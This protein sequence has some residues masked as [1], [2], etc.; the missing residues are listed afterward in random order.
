MTDHPRHTLHGSLPVS[1]PQPSRWT[2]GFAD[3]EL[4]AR[5]R[6]ERSCAMRRT[7]LVVLALILVMLAALVPLDLTRLE[8]E[9]LGAALALRAVFAGLLVTAAV[10]VWRRPERLMN[11]APGTGVGVTILTV[12][13]TFVYGLEHA[14][15]VLDIS[16]FAFIGLVFV[17]LLP[18]TGRWRWA[19]TGILLLAVWVV[20]YGKTDAGTGAEAELAGLFVSGVLLALLAIAHREDVLR[21]WQFAAIDRLMRMSTADPLTGVS[22]RRGFFDAAE[23]ARH[24]TRLADE[25]LS[26]V[27][28]DLDFFK[29]VNDQYG[30]AVGDDVLRRVA[31]VLGD[32]L[33]P[34]ETL[35]R[36]G[37]EEFAVL[38][39]GL[40]LERAERR[41]HA[42]RA[43]VEALCIRSGDRVVRMTASVGVACWM[44]EESIDAAL[45]RADLAMYEAKADGRNCVRREVARTA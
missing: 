45:A 6:S 31:R 41:A 9:G 2:G 11:V 14:N 19:L 12:A 38:L 20:A 22:N 34:G 29:R 4:E 5:F 24:R 42:L 25:P 3:E 27:L 1:L 21:R 35:A 36:L 18:N 44:P 37:G 33:K 43:E 40:S 15:P 30:H 26:V 32:A 28:L 7:F 39:P 10:M 17:L 8:D 16:Q 23:A 13:L